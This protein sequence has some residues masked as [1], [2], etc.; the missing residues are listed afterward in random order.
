MRYLQPKIIQFHVF[1]Q[2]LRSVFLSC[3]LFPRGDPCPSEG[4]ID[5]RVCS[6]AEMINIRK[7]APN[8]IFQ[9]RKMT[10]HKYSKIMTKII[11]ENK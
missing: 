5:E 10:S 6:K 8:F 3:Q 11:I 1:K 7:I 9:E 2:E 4:L